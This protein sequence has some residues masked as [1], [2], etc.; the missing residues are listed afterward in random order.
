MKKQTIDKA[1]IAFMAAVA[2]LAAGG[3]TAYGQ[4]VLMSYPLLIPAAIDGL[5][6]GGAALVSSLWASLVY[7]GVLLYTPKLIFG[8]ALT[9][10]EAVGTS[11]KQRKGAQ[12]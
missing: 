2:V 6:K 1:N 12:Q 10:G 8:S 11:L 4:F 3:M 5:H 9:I 7:V